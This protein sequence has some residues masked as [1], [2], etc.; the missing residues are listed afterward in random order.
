[1]KLS[2]ICKIVGGETAG[3][4]NTDIARLAKIEE[5]GRGDLTFLANPK[6]RKY[7]TSTGASAVLVSR[8]AHFDELDRR[9]DPLA[10]VRV[11]DP[12]LAFLQLIDRFHPAAAPLPRGIHATAVIASTAK[13]G[14][15]IAL[16][17][18]V[19]IG[20]RSVIGDNV[21]IYPCT[22]LADD[23]RLGHDS[24]LH[25][26]VAV[27]EQCVIGDRVIV[28]SGTVIGSDGF[29]FAPKGDGTFEKIPQR[30]IVVVEDD[31]EIGA[32]CTID[33]ATIGETRIEKGVKLDNLIQVAHNV[34]IGERTVIAAQSGISG[35]TKIGKECLIAGQVGFAGH[36]TI[37]DRTTFGAQSGVAKS[38]TEQ[39][40]TYFGYPARELQQSLRMDAALK[41]LPELLV[42]MRNIERRLQELERQIGKTS[43]N[44]QDQ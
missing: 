38:V 44:N 35:S 2:E 27:R 34:V 32:N 10:L 4:G 41:Q 26:N 13:L 33:R 30:G 15:N 7:L 18:H 42:E 16:G 25:A 20:E 24:T 19:V 21:S 17:A 23:V 31:V 3:D 5:A 22:V 6:Y 11:S 39:G 40:K 8:D 9:Q 12:Y 43:D 36:L 29:G 28:H 1:M 14:S 37:A